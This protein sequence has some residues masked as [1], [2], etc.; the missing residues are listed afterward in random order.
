MEP[1]ELE[2][3]ETSPFEMY[4]EDEQRIWSHLPGVDHWPFVVEQVIELEPTRVKPGKQ[5]ICRLAPGLLDP[6]ETIPLGI[7]GTSGHNFSQM[8]GVDHLP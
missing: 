7:F 1:G 8:P 2:P 4:G 5:M 3:D 6:D